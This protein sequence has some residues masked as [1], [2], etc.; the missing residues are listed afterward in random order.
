MCKCFTHLD[1]LENISIISLSIRLGS[2]DDILYLFKLSIF[3]I[4]FKRLFRFSLF[5]TPKS[6]ILTPLSTISL[7]SLDKT[8][9][10]TDSEL[11]D[12]IDDDGDWD[13][14][15]HDLG[16]DGLPATDKNEDGDYKDLGDI[17]PDKDGTEGN[18]IANC[19]EPNVDNIAE[20]LPNIHNSECAVK[21]NQIIDGEIENEC[22]FYF[23]ENADSITDYVY[24][25]NRNSEPILANYQNIKYGAYV[26]DNNCTKDFWNSNAKYDLIC[27]CTASGFGMIKSSEPI[28]LVKPVVFLKLNDWLDGAI[29]CTEQSCLKENSSILKVFVN[30]QYKTLH[31]YVV[32][33][34]TKPI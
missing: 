31:I 10:I 29:N 15:L 21:M 18:G 33:K 4:S 22:S 19:G 14:L 1:E 20:I 5:L 8:F 12:C 2:I 6:P 27:D 9:L 34:D 24:S 16:S 17:P 11:Y 25:G 3:S 30:K 13:P 32:V 7:I 26:P 28:S 23:S